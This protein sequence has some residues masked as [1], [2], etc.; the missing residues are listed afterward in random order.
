MPNIKK[1]ALVRVGFNYKVKH[2][3]TFKTDKAIKMLH[4]NNRKLYEIN[5]F[6]KLVVA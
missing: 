2:K 6:V 4:S 3:F 1:L 5:V